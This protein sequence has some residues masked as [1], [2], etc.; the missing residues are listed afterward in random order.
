MGAEMIFL[1]T[2][3]TN[4]YGNLFFNNSQIIGNWSTILW[5]YNLD[6]NKYS[7]AV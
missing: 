4:N 5:N 6:V 7:Y 3:V 1:K 2:Y